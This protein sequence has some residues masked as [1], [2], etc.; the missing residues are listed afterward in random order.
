M[1]KYFRSKLTFQIGLGLLLS[2]PR[3]SWADNYVV[4]LH[5]RPE[6][7]QS[8][9][10]LGTRLSHVN[11]LTLRWAA[12]GTPGERCCLCPP[13][14]ECATLVPALPMFTILADETSFC[15]IGFEPQSGFSDGEILISQDD[16]CNFDFLLDGQLPRVTFLGNLIACSKCTPHDTA[17][18][19][20][21]LAYFLVDA[22]PL[23]Q[24]DMN[25]D[26]D[27]TGSD[28]SLFI[29]VL[30]NPQSAGRRNQLAGD[31]NYDGAVNFDDIRPFVAIL[32]SR[33]PIP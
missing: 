8:L 7:P 1:G 22:E 20:L 32:L 12:F 4:Q 21:E 3:W 24:G 6:P 2:L 33:L 26:G 18:S 14:T 28:I 23:L 30:M 9:I 5:P 15:G 27:I 10:S 11:S 19:S 25:G 31:C 16:L 13:D 29:E 17:L